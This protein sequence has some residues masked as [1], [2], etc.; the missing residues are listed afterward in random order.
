MDHS[1]VCRVML[2]R[3][4]V[5]VDCVGSCGPFRVY[6]HDEYQEQARVQAYC[7]GCS[8]R[9]EV[10]VVARVPTAPTVPTFRESYEAQR[11]LTR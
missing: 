5:E 6:L 8:R 9:Y 4:D 11:R 7:P 10:E 2:L 1:K 3:A